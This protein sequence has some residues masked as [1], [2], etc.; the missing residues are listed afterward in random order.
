[1][2]YDTYRE[3]AMEFREICTA[4]VKPIEIYLLERA[5]NYATHTPCQS[6]TERRIG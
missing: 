6:R 2:L 3:V 4:L 1:M 5:S